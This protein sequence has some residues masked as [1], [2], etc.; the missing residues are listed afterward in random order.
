[1]EY[2]IE[3]KVTGLTMELEISRLGSVLEDSGCLD[4]ESGVN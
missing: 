4:E 2:F 3:E 1:M